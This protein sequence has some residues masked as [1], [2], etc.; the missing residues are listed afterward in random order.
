MV[1][2]FI[3]WLRNLFW[4]SIR[5]HGCAKSD[6]WHIP[7]CNNCYDSIELKAFNLIDVKLS[8]LTLR[9]LWCTASMQLVHLYASG[10]RW[11]LASILETVVVRGTWSLGFAP[12]HFSKII[13]KS[14][15]VIIF[16]Q[17]NN[18]LYM[19]VFAIWLTKLLLMG[20]WWKLWDGEGGWLWCYMLRLLNLAL[21]L[22]APNP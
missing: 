11:F 16:Q 1:I 9:H 12:E 17:A 6:I 3:T 13:A 7:N 15:I 5:I 8:A 18:Y 19:F 2:N 4:T 21:A 22:A 20:M 14:E 10:L